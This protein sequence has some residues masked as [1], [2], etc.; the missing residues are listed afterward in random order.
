MVILFEMKGAAKE[1]MMF[2]NWFIGW[3]L[4]AI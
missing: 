4:V 1:A 3:G 2:Q